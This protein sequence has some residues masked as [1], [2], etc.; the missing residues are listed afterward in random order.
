VEKEV[1]RKLMFGFQNLVLDVG[2]C[3]K[4]LGGNEMPSGIKTRLDGT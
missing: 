2:V 1:K 4:Q 3:K